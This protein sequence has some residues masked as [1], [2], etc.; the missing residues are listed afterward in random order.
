MKL[1]GTNLLTNNPLL[2]QGYS[3]GSAGGD[4]TYLPARAELSGFNFNFISLI[5]FRF[6]AEAHWVQDFRFF[7]L[8]VMLQSRG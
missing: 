7:P 2:P 1:N 8:H 5:L 4:S 3:C 6:C